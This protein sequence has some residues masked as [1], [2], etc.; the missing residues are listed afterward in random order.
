MDEEL[1]VLRYWGKVKPKLGSGPQ[2]HP[3]IYYID[4]YSTRYIT[5]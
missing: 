5:K 4:L 3:L 2:W 1:P